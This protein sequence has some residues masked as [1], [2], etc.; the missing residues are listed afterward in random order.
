MNVYTLLSKYMYIFL[1]IS[2]YWWCLWDC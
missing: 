2:R 1:M